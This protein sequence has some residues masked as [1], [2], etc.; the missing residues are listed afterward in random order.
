LQITGR[1]NIIADVLSPV[2]KQINHIFMMM[3]RFLL[4]G[5]GVTKLSLWS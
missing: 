3:I 5:G 1:E 4:H 2:L